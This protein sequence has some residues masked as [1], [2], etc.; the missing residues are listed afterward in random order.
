MGVCR[1]SWRL[2]SLCASKWLSSSLSSH[3][4]VRLSS[5]PGLRRG[6]F[7]EKFVSE[8]VRAEDLQRVAA[9]CPSPAAD[10]SWRVSS[11]G[12]PLQLPLV[13]WAA[14][15]SA[16]APPAVA[17]AFQH[18]LAGQEAA[19]NVVAIGPSALAGPVLPASIA[20]SPIVAA[21]HIGDCEGEVED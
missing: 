13:G 8:A 10:A 20:G 1:R 16:N 19:F 9:M 12:T 11:P 17:I 7:R 14:G 6:S 5:L 4:G 2:S 18:F 3:R 15:F 21:A